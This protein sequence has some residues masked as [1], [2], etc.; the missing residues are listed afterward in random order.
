MNNKGA[1]SA[2]D[3]T[4]YAQSGLR[5]CYSQTPNIMANRGPYE[6]LL[7]VP[8][9]V[10]KLNYFCSFFFTLCK[11]HNQTGELIIQLE[12]VIALEFVP[13]N[14]EVLFNERHLYLDTLW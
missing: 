5:L 2:T 11:I 4:E 14:V 9:V 8:L 3:Q 10:K 13:P 1:E 12:S 7:G 6:S